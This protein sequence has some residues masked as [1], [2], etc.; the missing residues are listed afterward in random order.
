MNVF[1][2]Q[3]VSIRSCRSMRACTADNPI[4]V[5]LCSSS[6]EEMWSSPNT[7]DDLAASTL[8]SLAAATVY[9]L[10]VASCLWE[11]CPYIPPLSPQRILISPVI[12]QITDNKSMEGFLEKTWK[13][14]DMNSQQAYLKA[15][16]DIQFRGGDP[17]Q[18]IHKHHD[19]DGNEHSKVTD[20]WSHLRNTKQFCLR[21]PFIQVSQ[22][23]VYNAVSPSDIKICHF[24]TENGSDTSAV[25]Y[26]G[27]CWRL[28]TTFVLTVRAQQS[29]QSQHLPPQN[30]KW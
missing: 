7:T 27:G 17:H 23:S 18:I 6:K 30:T 19:H 26:S 11:F 16:R 3:K 8:V 9:R 20:G 29:K 14:A 25:F 12:L 21:Y 4:S 13:I 1:H 28:I 22:L 15:I 2:I 10:A 5:V 24:Y